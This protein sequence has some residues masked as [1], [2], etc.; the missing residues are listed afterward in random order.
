MVY[1]LHFNKAV[2]KSKDSV[3]KVQIQYCR[4]SYSVK[5]IKIASEKAF[6]ICFSCENFSSSHSPAFP[7]PFAE[8]VTVLLPVWAFL[9]VWKVLSKYLKA[10]EIAEVAPW[11]EGWNVRNT[12]DIFSDYER[13]GSQCNLGGA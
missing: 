4:S 1:K 6:I 2:V 11:E 5:W 7:P 8:K 3:M 12:T 10:V 9:S 13:S